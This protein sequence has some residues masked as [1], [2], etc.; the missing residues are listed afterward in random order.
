MRTQWESTELWPRLRLKLKWQLV[1]ISPANRYAAPGDLWAIACYFNPAGYRSKLENYVAYDES[2]AA[3]GIPRLT[4]ECA[5]ED[6]P[7][8]LPEAD[9]VL[10]V[11]TGAVMWQKERLLNIAAAH[12]PAACEKVAW[13]DCDVLFSNPAWA[14]ETSR[15]LDEVPVA[16]PYAVAIR[17]PKGAREHTAG[18]ASDELW[19]GFAAVYKRHPNLMLR[20]D[21]ARHGHT[22]FA[23]AARREIL[24]RHGLYDACIAGSGDHMMAHA[25]C[26]DFDGRCVR[27]I[28]GEANM[29]RDH[30]LAWSRAVYRDT[31]AR[32]GYV[33]GAVLHLWHGETANRRYVDRNR[34]LAAFGFDPARHLRAGTD[35]CWDWTPEGSALNAWARNYFARRKED[36]E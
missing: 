36:G 10:R 28:I 27:R 29:H 4:V 14:M 9:H 17:L 13:L 19:G 11:R 3:S 6:E 24:A 1:R 26:G 8:Q 20:G 30:F 15:Q 22:G 18:D 16:Q 31:R 2:L 25:F 5:F 34:E 33:P 35:G 12:L 21:F 32:I 7:F 23:W